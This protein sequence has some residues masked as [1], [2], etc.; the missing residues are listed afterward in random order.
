MSLKGIKKFFW[1][2]PWQTEVPRPGAESKLQ[3]EPVPQLWQCRILNLLH[4]ARDQNPHCHRNTAGSLTC[5]TT[6]GTLKG[7]N[8]F[9]LC[10]NHD[11]SAFT[12]F[13]Y[14]KIVAF[15]SCLVA[16]WVK[17]LAL[18]LQ[19]LG[20]LLWQGFSYWPRNIHMSRACP[21]PNC[22]I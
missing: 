18:S 2:H 12:Y 15:R 14:L 6:V 4:Q 10:Y 19:Q 20:S 21:R 8:I 7:T 3:L 13:L 11:C 22:K 17:D 9:V 16:Q 1:P 5:C